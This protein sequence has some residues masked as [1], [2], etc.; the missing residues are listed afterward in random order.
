[1][2]CL[3]QVLYYEATQYMKKPKMLTCKECPLQEKCT[4]KAKNVTQEEHKTR[5]NS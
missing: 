3:M 4:D 1:M 5:G 2:V